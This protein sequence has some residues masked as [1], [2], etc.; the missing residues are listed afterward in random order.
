MI[1]STTSLERKDNRGEW[2]KKG[3]EVGKEEWDEEDLHRPNIT[4]RGE[5]DYTDEALALF[6]YL[7]PLISAL[8][9]LQIEN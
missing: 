2:K 4:R 3:E 7:K 1:H 6:N 9:A 8:A 5:H